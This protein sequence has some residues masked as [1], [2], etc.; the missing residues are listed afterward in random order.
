MQR[1]IAVLALLAMQ[2]PI[3]MQVVTRLTVPAGISVGLPGGE[4]AWL[5][6]LHVERFDPPQDVVV[7]IIRGGRTIATRRFRAGLDGVEHR[8]LSIA[9]HDD[10]LLAGTES[11]IS[12]LIDCSGVCS[13]S[14]T[15]RS[16]SEPWRQPVIVPALPAQLPGHTR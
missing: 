16:S 9:L 8:Q 14:V 7:E 11:V 13:A 15:Q 10:P 4:L 2:V 12:L 1:L 3:D 6:V 5:D